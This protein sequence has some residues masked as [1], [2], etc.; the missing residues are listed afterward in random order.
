MPGFNY[1]KSSATATRLI[2]K[3]GKPV[4]VEVVGAESYDPATDTV[5]STSTATPIAAVVLPFNNQAEKL[6]PDTVIYTESSKLLADGAV[7]VNLLDVIIINDIN[8]T[9]QY[10]GAL[11]PNAGAPI[12]QTIIVVR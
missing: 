7:I 12:L 8:Y 4:T 3:F 2:K 10:T 9:V 1:D 6:L 11:N 5:T